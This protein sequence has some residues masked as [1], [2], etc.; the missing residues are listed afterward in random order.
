MFSNNNFNRDF[1]AVFPSFD[2]L[3]VGNYE[4]KADYNKNIG[5]YENDYTDLIT[6]LN[7]ENSG[8]SSEIF[9]RIKELTNETHNYNNSGGNIS[10]NMGGVTQNFSSDSQSEDIMELFVESLKRGLSTCGNKF[11]EEE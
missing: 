11:L 7:V 2:N 5:T 10:I 8:E 9:S 4:S 6:G 1:N 3:P